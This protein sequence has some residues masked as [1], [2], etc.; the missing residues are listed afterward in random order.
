MEPKLKPELPQRTVQPL[1]GDPLEYD[2]FMIPLEKKSA[3]YQDRLYYL[4]Q[5]TKGEPNSLVRSCLHMKEE[6]G[7][8]EA[9]RLLERNFGSKYRIAEAYLSKLRQW[10]NITGNNTT[11][12][13]ELSLF[14]IECKNTMSSLGYTAE[15]DSTSN[16]RMLVSKLPYGLRDNWR[17]IADNIEEERHRMVKF[18]DLI[19][20]IGKRAR[21]MT[22][23]S[24]GKISNDNERD[25]KAES[26]N[27]HSGSRRRGTSF[28]TNTKPN[29]NG[30]KSEESLKSSNEHTQQPCTNCHG[31]HSLEMC[32]KLLGKPIG[33]RL[34]YMRE[35]GVCFGCLRKG[36]HR[37]KECKKKLT[38]KTCS[39]HHP[40]VL[41]MNQQ[42]AQKSPKDSDNVTC[43]LT[44]AGNTSSP[45]LIPVI[46]HSKETGMSVET[47]A[48]LDSGSDAVF[49]TE[50]LQRQLNV[51][52]KKTKLE[53][54][55]ITD[56]RM[57]DSYILH[58]LEVSDMDRTTIIPLPEVYTQ[59][60]IPAD[61][62]QRI[63]QEDISPWSYLQDVELSTHQ[64]DMDHV[65]ILI[66]NNIPKAWEP[67]KVI[68]SQNGGPYA[69]RTSLGWVVHGVQRYCGTGITVNRITVQ[70]D[71]EQQLV[72]L[73]NQDFSERLVDDQPEKSIKDKQFLKDVEETVKLTKERH[74]QIDL[75]LQDKKRI[76]PSNIQQ[77]EVRAQHL[78]RKFSKSPPFYQ[79]Y[80]AVMDD[81]ILKGYAERV[82]VEELQGPEGRTW[83]I[84][85]HGV[86][87]PRKH[88]L[89]V[90][91]DCAASYKGFSLNK[92]LLQGPDL[93]SSL[94]GVILRFRQD[95]V[96]LMGDIEGMF[97]QVKVTN[98]DRDLLRFLWWQDSDIERPIE[99]YRMCV[100]LFG[101]TSS[102]SCANYAL[103][104]T[105]EAASSRYSQHV[106]NTIL[107]NF[108]V[109][110][111]LRSVQT[112]AEAI[113]LVKD[114]KEV[115][116]SGGFR[117]TKW[118]S[119]S[120]EVLKT[121][122]EA[123]RAKDVR[124]L[125]LSQDPLPSDRA[126]GM[127]WN[128]ERDT[129]GYSIDL[130]NK[131]ATRRGIL[132]TVS[133][134]Y[135]PLGLI[136]PVILPAK[137]ILQNLCQLRLGWD[138]QIPCDYQTIWQKW[139]REVPKL[140]RF[141]VNRCIKAPDFGPFKAQL[142]HF[143]D[144]SEVGYGTATY[145]RMENDNDQVH[146]S[147][148][149]SKSRVSPLK[150]I[151]IPRMELTAA[152]VAV[153][154]NHMIQKELDIPIEETFFWTDSMTVLRYINNDSL[155][156]HTF[157]ANRVAL[158]REGSEP[159]QWRY[160]NTNSNPADDCS[161][162]LKVDDFL[163]NER[164]K[165]GPLYL[166]QPE[167]Q[168]P[169]TVLGDA[170]I[171]PT[172]DP[173]VKRK[174]TI[175]TVHAEESA[176]ALDRLIE[177]Y[178]SWYHLRRGIAWI[179]RIKNCL[180]SQINQKKADEVPENKDKGDADIAGL[181]EEDKVQQASGISPLTLVDLQKAEKAVLI[182][183]QEGAFPEEIQ[184]L[185]NPTKDNQVPDENG[186]RKSTN[187][188]KKSSAIYKLS[189]IMKDGMLRVGG[190]LAKAALPE[191][192]RHPIILPKKSHVSEL[193]L[194]NIHH[195]TGHSGRS[196]MLACLHRKYWVLSANA[197]AR[198][199]IHQCV[200][201][202][203]QR[204]QVGEQQM[205]DLP[206]DRLTPDEPPFTR[207]G[208]DYFGPFEVKRGR[209]IVKR[210]GVIFT[211]LSTRAIHLEKA[212]YLD[213]DSC[214]NAIRRF[215][216][217]RGQVK[218]IRSDNGTNLVGA[219]KE[220]R[221]EIE[222]WN[223][224]KIH[225][226]LLQK[227]IQWTFNPPAGSHF[228]GVWERQIRTV[229]KVMMSI[230]GQQTLTDESLCTF[231]C[232]VEAIVNS[233]PIT[234]VSGDA[235]DLEALTPNHILLLKGKPSLPPV[236]ANET[237]PHSRKRWKQVQFLSDLFWKRWSSEYL[238]QLQKRQK[239]V[240][241]KDNFKNGDVVLLI[242][243]SRPRNSW[244]LG[245]I[246]ATMPAKDGLVR[247]VQVKTRSTTL[248]RP[249]C[250]LC[251]LLASDE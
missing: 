69:C 70:N 33:E 124:S 150:Q 20:F 156:F 83:Y 19:D 158:I 234:T 115:C 149:M 100:H 249:V 159:S 128:V 45:S 185:S 198:R 218:I 1:T 78:K 46:I 172:D 205:A 36:T 233:R 161:R 91:Y 166:H 127:M 74:Y 169:K 105:A 210:Y 11:G 102:P 164:W 238:Y 219:E 242:D 108:Y 96:A 207:V 208:V 171:D 76:F 82:P 15:L 213:T 84:P 235:N 178:S 110:D 29:N 229:R 125:D 40:S 131:P 162:G 34:K 104:K 160:V 12:L 66:G 200:V 13:H 175:N 188:V 187:N 98:K 228:G 57:V 231:F 134:V 14:L 167:N 168:W 174:V 239:W 3:S 211:C 71:I 43:G 216:A 25:F 139:L 120:R 75:P 176:R 130:H 195:Y 155:R 203:R 147:L 206:I 101:A 157:V 186:K 241:P 53:I 138:Q 204:A 247:Q 55:T 237:G 214:I 38:C 121:I 123:D 245:R 17:T 116:S 236:L 65:G 191:E 221:K 179:L 95:P 133:S 122:P 244:Q 170:S 10:P 251:L 181:P 119:N 215:V 183:V 232:E 27:N 192:T 79:E 148:L 47:M 225:D 30:G 112:E 145:L 227:N 193:I 42:D 63:T 23:P 31:T 182:Y 48:Y 240:R 248:I 113:S 243:K 154:V 141:E 180:L 230:M 44:G 111:C 52:G 190:R 97:H 59:D 212:D 135:D 39:K 223:N 94:V 103:R 209:S 22:N 144:A 226:C 173:E 67:F 109:D 68:N 194:R 142:H 107:R 184:A 118:L 114:L 2:A 117:L 137:Q 35:L 62:N 92:E 136:A 196:H 224:A 6:E 246:I 18:C 197:A 24:F 146:C 80:K 87:H 153:K 201:C 220:L 89:R 77:A 58:G 5:F 56:E 54:Q 202:R 90:V 163:S 151:S 60:K 189:P 152:T 81:M 126:L 16:I 37:S 140:S 28:A 88:K 41:H 199:I 222:K 132:S 86:Y 250:K 99:Q 106:T 32:P 21:I 129:F 26:R 4:E 51:K 61:P 9:K 64:D 177:R 93:T 73:Y 72:D 85:H 217:R 165:H 143:S 50:T 49:L 8:F 7:F